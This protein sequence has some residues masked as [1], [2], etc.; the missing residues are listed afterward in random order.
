[1]HTEA[2]A[3]CSRIASGLAQK[4]PPFRGAPVSGICA[5][6]R[7]SAKSAAKNTRGRS[8]TARKAPSLEVQPAARLMASLG[9][10]RRKVLI[11][12]MRGAERHRAP[13]TARG[14]R[15]FGSRPSLAR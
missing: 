4:K 9:G 15:A 13:L 6:A 2:V 5:K 7:S 12:N 14:L 10:F 1:M 8:G 3:R 11:R